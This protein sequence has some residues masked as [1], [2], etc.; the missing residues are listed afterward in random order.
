M[1]HR[2]LSISAHG[3][4]VDAAR[5][6]VKVMSKIV[7]RIKQVEGYPPALAAKLTKK[8]KPE[9]DFLNRS[10]TKMRKAP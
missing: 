2:M 9:M 8:G 6:A 3:V 10:L 7:G 4:C 1:H 5:A